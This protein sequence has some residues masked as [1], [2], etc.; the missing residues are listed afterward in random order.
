M[1]SILCHN[2]THGIIIKQLTYFKVQ[3]NSSQKG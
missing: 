3:E 2:Y 1:A